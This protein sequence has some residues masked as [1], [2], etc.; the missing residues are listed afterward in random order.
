MLWLSP[1]N[2]QV[3]GDDALQKVRNGEVSFLEGEFIAFLADTVSPD[4]VSK[5]FDQLGYEISF[6]DIKPLLIY[7][8]NSPDDSVINRLRDH[9]SVQRVFS[10]TTP[11]DTSYFKGVLERQ[12]VSG[13]ELDKALTRLLESQSSQRTFIEFDYSI[14]DERL[15][16]LMRSFRS[17]AYDVTRDIPRTVNIQ[18]EPGNEQEIMERI[19]QLLFVESTA[20]IGVLR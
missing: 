8:V 9:S 19:E 12:G 2:A 7:I 10:E 18:C 3:I 4:F 6:Q 17:V 14:N 5:K 13:T 11:V 20:L 15:K 1:L 16:L